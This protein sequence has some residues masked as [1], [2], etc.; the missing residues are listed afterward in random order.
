MILHT[1]YDYDILI[2]GH[3]TN[4]FSTPNLIVTFYSYWFIILL[5]KVIS[6]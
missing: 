5:S 2:L 4:K 1:L 6:F 3:G